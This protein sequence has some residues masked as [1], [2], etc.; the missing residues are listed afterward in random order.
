VVDE[1]GNTIGDEKA[2]VAAGVAETSLRRRIMR[3]YSAERSLEAGSVY[4]EG[5]AHV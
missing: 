2:R 4:A 3:A 1:D 5:A